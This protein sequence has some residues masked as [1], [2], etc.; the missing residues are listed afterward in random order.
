MPRLSH[1]ADIA[2]PERPPGIVEHLGASFGNVFVRRFHGGDR[3]AT[4]FATVHRSLLAQSGQFIC[5]CVCP[6]LDNSG[7]S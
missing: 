4:L 6:L 1:R 2:S 3:I 5:V 7:Q